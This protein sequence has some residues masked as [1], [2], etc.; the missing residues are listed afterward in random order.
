MFRFHNLKAALNSSKI[1]S[2]T[3]TPHFSSQLHIQALLSRP[4]SSSKMTNDMSSFAANT[5]KELSKFSR[6]ELFGIIPYEEQ[7]KRSSGSKFFK[8]LDPATEQE[9]GSLPEMETAHV[10]DAIEKASK[11]FKS[12]SKITARERK[13]K[14]QKWYDLMMKNQADL[15][16]MITI[17]S[18]KPL[19]ESMGE[20]AYGASFIEWFSQEAIRAYGDTMPVL[21]PGQRMMTIKQPVGVVGIITPWNFP[22]AMIT[23]K[24]GAALAAG[25]TAVVKPAAETPYSAIAM[26]NLAI[27]SGIPEDAFII[28]TTSS[29]VTDIGL[30][31]TTNPLVKKVSFTGSTAVGKLLLKQA[32][33]T[34]KKSS[35]ELGGNAPFIVFDDANL[36][37]AVSGLMS[38][39]F[40]NAGQ[41]CVCAN[42]IFVH[43]SVYDRFISMV[44]EKIKSKIILG[45]G[46]TP[47]V[48]FGPL[49]SKKATERMNAIIADAKSKG[50]K[51]VQVLDLPKE[52]QEGYFYPPTILVDATSDMVASTDEIFGPICSMIKFDSEEH[53]LEMVNQVPVG[54]AGYFYSN[55]LSRVFKMAEALETGMVGVNTGL[56]SNEVLPFGGIKESGIGREGSKYGLDEYLYLKAITLNF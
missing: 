3:T 52:L 8:V 44:I 7:I 32:S 37:D 19:V 50:A 35:M 51:A 40:R 43:S 46:T 33:S 49:I 48:T 47:N 17:E 20:I 30:E 54:L 29:N 45:H 34:V 12:W 55:N 39:K 24:V 10:R 41:T 26:R 25:C 27:E 5:S 1:L 22:N 18:G 13:L 6:P 53:L 31:L 56:I 15:A 36:E 38:A 28:V 14:L 21:A 23:R 16:R 9:I 2:N 11:E 4:F 42:R